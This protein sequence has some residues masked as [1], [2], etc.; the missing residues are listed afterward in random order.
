MKNLLFALIPFFLLFTLAHAQVTEEWVKRYN[1]TGGSSD[2]A[3]FVRLDA[4]GNIYVT[5][6][7]GGVGTGFDIVTV[8]YNPA[9]VL[10]WV[11]RYNGTS[12]HHDK[13]NSMFV[14]AAGNVYI[15]G[16][17]N[18]AG[19]DLDYITIKYNTDGVQQW[20][21]VYNGPVN[22]TDIGTDITVDLEGNVYVTGRSVGGG[23]FSGAT[24]KYNS[25]GVLQW[26]H[27]QEDWAAT[28]LYIGV[29]GSGNVYTSGQHS[30]SSLN[31]NFYIVK[32]DSG[33]VQ[34]WSRNLSVSVFYCEPRSMVV[35][36]AGN[37]VVAGMVWTSLLERDYYTFKYN[38][39]G[40][41]LWA[42]DYDG[43]AGADIPTSMAMDAS[44]NIYVTGYSMPSPSIS[45]D[46]VTIKY[47]SSGIQQWVKRYNG[48][49]D[50][51]DGGNSVCLDVFGYIYVS[52]Q[53]S[54]PGQ[55]NSLDYLTIKYS[56][57]GTQLWVQT[58]NGTANYSDVASSNAVDAGGNVYVTGISDGFGSYSDYVTIKYSQP[59]HIVFFITDKIEVLKFKVDTLVH[60]NILPANFGHMLNNNLTGAENQLYR[61]HPSVAEIRMN[62]FKFEVNLLMQL[63]ILS[64]QYGQPLVADAN[65]IIGM[66]ENMNGNGNNVHQSE[67]P[68]SFSLEQ[69]YPNPFNPSTKIKFEIPFAGNVSVKVYD[70]LGREAATL[71]NDY[72]SA[73]THESVWNASGYS[74][75]VYFLKLSAEIDG[76]KFEKSMKMILAK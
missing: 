6:A 76:E 8:K 1:G 37:V 50:N 66:I 75:G 15:H 10:K 63:Q 46:C 59:S 33:G 9:G 40:D 52:G 48:P 27:R 4:S 35:D 57:S 70:V 61:N 60:S 16:F 32:Y 54:A 14:D 7:S 21:S 65:E 73:G 36:N 18:N 20:A 49:A 19:S 41:L 25:S 22:S 72:L 74:S 44:G 29:D 24:I 68:K 26:V 2:E 71:V 39:S 45:S 12:N 56:P 34:Q 11:Q 53:T 23:L 64:P 55:G 47:N 28:G 42:K 13:P 38:S 17:C 67:E 43:G 58:Y 30:S 62:L 51:S 31:P 69:N 3:K 5:G